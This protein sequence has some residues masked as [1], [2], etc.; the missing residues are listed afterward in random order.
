[1]FKIGDRIVYPMHGV[2]TIDAIEKKEILGHRTEYYII[3]IINNGMK[4]MIPVKSPGA[5]PIRGII[6]KNEVKTSGPPSTGN[7]QPT[8]R[9]LRPQ[10]MPVK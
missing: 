10:R 5:S 8:R 2:G 9:S 3:R 7:T 1:M 6:S 4:V